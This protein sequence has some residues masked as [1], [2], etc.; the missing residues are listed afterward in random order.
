MN[1]S[2]KIIELYKEGQA[3]ILLEWIYAIV[4]IGALL[5][6]GLLALVN[7]S[8]GVGFLIIPLVSFVAF[9]MNIVAWALIKLLIESAQPELKP[10]LSNAAEATKSSKTKKSRTSKSKRQSK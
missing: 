4:S 3:L 2:D 9:S 1:W 5:L 7:Q 6:A 10:S 8:L